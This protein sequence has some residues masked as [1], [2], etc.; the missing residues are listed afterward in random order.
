MRRC[1]LL[2]YPFLLL[3]TVLIS[4]RQD[5]GLSQDLSWRN[6]G[7]ANMMGRIAAVDA[8]NTDYRHVLCASASGGVFKSTNG[9]MSW[10]AIFDRY[11]A[12]SIGSVKL[13]QNHPEI[14][15]VGTGEAANRNSSG[16]GDGIYKS[17]DGGKNFQHMG[18]TS[19][20]HIAEIALHPTDPDIVYAAAVGH[21]WGYNGER[22]LFKSTDGGRNWQKLTNGLPNDGKTG[23]TEIIM[24]PENPDILFAGFYER[25]RLPYWYTSGGAHGGVFKSIDGGKSWKKL[26]NGLP[27][28]ET[29]MIDISISPKFPDIMV[30]AIEADEKLPD[31]VPGSGV[32]RSDDGGENWSFLLKHAVRPFYHGQIEI[33]PVDPQ[34]IY[35]VS[36]DFQYSTDGGKSF[37]VPRWRRD[38]GDDHDL[39]IAP[40][41]NKIMYHCT[42]QGLKL[43]IDG[44]E[45]FLSFNN[46]AI[47]QYYAIGT[48]MR[49][50]Y[51]V[52]G[53]LQDNGLWI[54]PSN[55]REVRGI[56][57]MHNTW[58]GEGDGFHAH[59]DPTDWRTLYL[60][61]HVGFATRLNLETR[62]HTYI[63]P[64][65]ETTVNFADYF[66]PNFQETDI[67][68][69]IYPGEQWFFY[70]NLERPKLPAQFRFNWSSPLSLSPNNPRTLYF[71]G[72]Y[73]FKSVDRGE[74][75]RIISPDLTSNDPKWRN[76]SKSGHL[77][78]SVTGGENHFT[79]ITIAESPVNDALVWAGT[80]DGFLHV[81]KDG[82]VSWTEVGKN[83][84]GVD[85][86]IWVSRVEPSQV[87]EG[88]CYVTLDNHR[89]DDMKPYVFVTED[90]GVHWKNI[91]NN[92]PTDF[93]AYVIREDPVNPNLLFV[94]TEEAVHFSYNRGAE[95]H[96]LMANMPTVAIHDLVIHPRD[97]DLVAG[98]HG[99]SIW[100]LDDISPLRQLNDD[101]LAQPLHLF[102]SRQAT[103]WL[104]INTGRKQLTFEFRGRNPRP[105]GYIQFWLKDEA[106]DT[107]AITVSDPF[108]KMSTSWKTTAKKG[109]NRKYWNFSFPPTAT[110]VTQ[111][112]NQL[113]EAI[114]TIDGQLKNVEKKALLEKIKGL[115]ATAE[116]VSNVNEVRSQLVS[117]FSGYAGGRPIFGKKLLAVDAPAGRYKVTVVAGDY[118]AEEWLDVREDPLGGGEE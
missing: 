36:R 102:Q 52:V 54:G 67:V 79:I 22:G 96:E 90:F 34:N 26:Q 16:W 8:L 95:W 113:T 24:H 97:G 78:N 111:L 59:V 76:P 107:I 3:S 118:T 63:T 85:R 116:D 20:H 71:G 92:L 5:N 100:I 86:R 88:R 53:G 62:A 9:G 2:L 89:Y 98:T 39:W 38:G 115:L 109:L 11:G 64:T 103:K 104:R 91:T 105:G 13:N 32:Y 7:P 106:L 82:G 6:I 60:V 72:N 73:L 41:D 18:L 108:S 70:E 44:C 19:T 25:L 87:V 99:R 65:P 49:D 48:D 42:D 56:L 93:S 1:Y 81:T 77:T 37:R 28:G 45:S 101:I 29:G 43:T 94:G 30:A 35:V 75:W 68:Y 4:Q 15:W 84:P 47:G 31:G 55:S 57:N 110:A 46:M 114:T 74:N 80:D 23:C 51:W 117:E 14:I 112:K 83:L 12:G 33:D 50:P 58:V 27:T 40:Y 10:E 61:N 17:I 69:T 66:D 21:L